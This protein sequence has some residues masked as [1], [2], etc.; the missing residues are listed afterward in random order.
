MRLLGA[1]SAAVAVAR[2]DLA[3]LWAS[4]VPWVVAALV[5]VVVGVLF[6]D[7]LDARRQAVFQP[8]VP[9]A[10]FVLLVTAPVLAMRSF[11]EEAKVGTLDV[12][13][14]VPVPT[15]ALVAGKWLAA[16][17]TAW[18]ALVPLGV[19]AALLAWWGDPDTG[20]I[21]AGTIGL[22]LLAAAAGAVGVL[23]SS[24]TSSQPVAAFGA[25]VPLLLAWF[26]QPST[27]QVALRDLTARLSLSERLRG[28][29][30]G[31][32]D[33]GDVAYFAAVAALALLA[34]VAVLD[35]RRLR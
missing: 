3:A 22:A 32:L 33:A 15:P 30:D 1:A 24:F 34:A 27:S 23:A 11:A 10:G 4:P 5:Q 18:L 29:A 12:L 25:V 6:V 17:L 8:L 13:L 28:F 35:L 20:P 19:H 2:K 9:I 21:V 7:T 31:A 26:L 16:T 14:A